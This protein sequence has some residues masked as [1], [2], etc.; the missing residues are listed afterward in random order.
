M[1]LG[2]DNEPASEPVV[3]EYRPAMQQDGSGSISAG[4]A[5]P[6]AEL[7]DRELQMRLI[8][9][10]L[11]YR[12]GSGALDAVL[13]SPV[14]QL[15]SVGPSRNGSGGWAAADMSLRTASGSSEPHPLPQQQR[16]LQ[17]PMGAEQLQGKGSSRLGP[18]GG[19]SG[20][21]PDEGSN[22]LTRSAVAA[23]VGGGGPGGSAQ[24][25][26]LAAA[27]DRLPTAQR[28]EMLQLLIQRE[29]AELGTAA[30]GSGAMEC[31]NESAEGEGG[32]KGAGGS[33]GAAAAA[34]ARDINSLG[35]GGQALIHTFAGLGYDWAISVLAAAGADVNLVDA[36]GLTPLHWAAAR[37]H[38]AAVGELLTRGADPTRLSPATPSA[39]AKLPAD[40]AADNG[41]PGMA[42]FLA[43]AALSWAWNRMQEGG[44]GSGGGSGSQ[45][46]SAGATAGRKRSRPGLGG[47]GGGGGGGLGGLPGGMEGGDFAQNAAASAK[48]V[49]AAIE[50]RWVGG[51]MS[52]DTVA[53][54]FL[55][56]PLEMKK[57]WCAA[58]RLRQGA[59]LNLLLKQPHGVKESTT[60]R[61]LVLLCRYRQQQNDGSLEQQ[62]RASEQGPPGR[63][64]SQDVFGLLGQA[65]AG[66]HSSEYQRLGTVRKQSL[67]S[68]NN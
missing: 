34:A 3:F 26:L 5:L 59:P 35:V 45:Q 44:S 67:D 47:G 62:G 14:S 23:L 25:D 27:M 29:V 33:S 48:N 30:G 11:G 36:A 58:P 6:A 63:A 9:T 68:C 19:R 65:P 12:G 46:G 20:G 37:G 4:G 17:E 55:E 56:V 64:G 21:M 51:D 60:S 40:L 1:V 10:L 22:N 13:P 7:A 41:H 16:Q 15:G 54:A 52:H 43:E 53:Q 57:L 42:A 49:A 66:A 38:E 8:Q 28:E 39:P 2:P 32:S 18:R 24:Q 31:D 50:D 61:L